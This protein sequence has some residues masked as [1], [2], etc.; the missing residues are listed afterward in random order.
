MSRQ[1]L[2]T[3]IAVLHDSEINGAVSWFYD[4]VGRVKLG[5]EAIGFGGGF[6]KAI[7]HYSR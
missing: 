2:G 1:D 7:G 6:S 3:I 4:G 5:D